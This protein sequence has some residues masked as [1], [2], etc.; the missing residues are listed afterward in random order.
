[1]Y[2]PMKIH[3]PKAI[4]PE[5]KPHLFEVVLSNIFYF[6]SPFG[7]DESNLTER[8]IFQIGWEKQPPTS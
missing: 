5:H 2:P 6:S 7:E 3:I 1:M 4:K 8:N